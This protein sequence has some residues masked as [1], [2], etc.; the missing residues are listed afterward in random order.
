MSRAVFDA[1]PPAH[2]AGPP[3]M[4]TPRW[5]LQRWANVLSCCLLLGVPPVTLAA[6]LTVNVRDVP[7]EVGRVVVRLFTYTDNFPH[8]EG[9]MSIQVG[10]AARDLPIRLTFPDLPAGRYAVAAFHD[11]DCN[12]DLTAQPY[13]VPIESFAFSGIRP[14]RRPPTF[15]EAAVVVGGS[16]VVLELPLVRIE[17]S[18][19]G[20]LSRPLAA[21]PHNLRVRV[22]GAPEGVIVA[23]LVSE[24]EKF[25]PSQEGTDASRVAVRPFNHGPV[26]LQFDQL[27]P[28]RYA[29]VAFR[30]LDG[31]LRLGPHES[32]TWPGRKPGVL[33]PLFDDIFTNVPAGGTVSMTVPNTR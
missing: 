10:P 30:D 3:M 23:Q 25:P 33:L 5:T 27:P 12:G 4:P 31:D 32:P 26:T 22:E 14:P 20:C 19:P 2:H 15:E 24:L 7:S 17:T 21:G 8:G 11:A 9:A 28:G 18:A 29:V 16:P 6:D 13:G 1:P